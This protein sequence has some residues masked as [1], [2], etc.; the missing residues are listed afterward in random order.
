MN[1]YVWRLIAPLVLLAALGPWLSAA[2]DVNWQVPPE[3]ITVDFGSKDLLAKTVFLNDGLAYEV[4]LPL[5]MLGREKVTLHAKLPERGKFVVAAAQGAQVDLKTV[6][7]KTVEIIN[8][9]ELFSPDE[10]RAQAEAVAMKSLDKQRQQAKGETAKKKKGELESYLRRKD[11]KVP[12]DDDEKLQAAY[13][14]RRAIELGEDVSRAGLAAFAKQHPQWAGKVEQERWKSLQD[15]DLFDAW[16]KVLAIE[17]AHEYLQR[18]NIEV[19]VTKP[20]SEMLVFG[21]FTGVH[22]VLSGVMVR[23]QDESPEKAKLRADAQQ[24]I[25]TM[26]QNDVMRL[27]NGLVVKLLCRFLPGVEEGDANSQWFHG[28]RLVCGGRG[29]GAIRVAGQ[30]DPGQQDHADWWTLI[31]YDS[32][33]TALEF[34]K[35]ADIRYEVLPDG[36]N[37]RL[38]V[39]A[40]GKKPVSYSFELRPTVATAFM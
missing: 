26:N 36:S 10:L 38:R 14:R 28:Q 35:T 30:L 17:P 37:A 19:D 22:A 1:R 18:V 40:T 25:R 20:G 7:D 32:A 21:R 13:I 15:G 16:V 31:K 27:R 3:E 6:D 9:L 33:T 11:V 24:A 8:R 4:P 23:E 39:I 12:K 2:D 34:S 29:I 5:V